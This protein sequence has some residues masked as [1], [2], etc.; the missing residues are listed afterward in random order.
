MIIAFHGYGK[1]ADS[2]RVWSDSISNAM[3]LSISLFEHGESVWREEGG[4]EKQDFKE[5]LEALIQFLNLENK[6]IVSLGYSIGARYAISL[7]CLLPHLFKSCILLAPDGFQKVNVV[8]I[9]ARHQWIPRF[10][11]H[12]PD[13]VFFILKLLTFI[14][15]LPEGVFQFYLQK[16]NSIPKRA[17]LFTVWLQTA[18]I[19]FSKTQIQQCFQDYSI[20]T[21]CILGKEDR[22]IK[23]SIQS[24]VQRIFPEA[25]IRIVNE[26]HALINPN[27][28]SVVNEFII[29]LYSH[30]LVSSK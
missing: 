19:S 7:T 18:A 9:C 22:I 29:E 17:R 13:I 12:H 4:L 2:Y 25:R 6:F 15:I 24:T 10:L 11:I 30:F 27:I 5:I 3:V 21:F 14:Q 16:F 28:G 23:P 1:D 26:G 8:Q 20:S